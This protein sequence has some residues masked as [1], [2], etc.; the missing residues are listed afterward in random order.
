[1]RPQSAQASR[2]TTTVTKT[3]CP[4]LSSTAVTTVDRAAT[5]PTER[6]MPRVTTT[7]NCAMPSTATTEAATAMFSRFRTV[8]KNSEVQEPTRATRT[9]TASR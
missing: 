5:E 6:S 2:A 9:N 1:M 7:M 8:K 4:C 3:P